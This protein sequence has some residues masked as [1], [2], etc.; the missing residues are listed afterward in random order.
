MFKEIKLSIENTS[1]PYKYDIKK[2][3]IIIKTIYDLEIG[4][5]LKIYYDEN[6]YEIV[7]NKDISFQNGKKGEIFI[8]INKKDLEFNLILKNNFLVKTVFKYINK[9][10]DKDNLIE[11]IKTFLIFHIEQ[12]DLNDL[13][14]NIL[15]N[16]K[17]LEELI[18]ENEDEY[19]RICTLL[20]NNK[21][22][23]DIAKNMSDLELM[24]LI[25]SYIAVPFIPKI[26]QETFNNLIKVA[27]D[28][29]YALENIWRLGMSF[30]GK[31]Y[32]YDLLDDFFVNQKDIWYLGE[33]LSGIYQVNQ[34][35]LVNKIIKT[36]DKEFI[37]QVLNDELI[38]RHLDDKYQKILENNI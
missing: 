3:E 1:I 21:T 18:I 2:D 11:E 38:S 24:L 35:K 37:K 31:G 20:I 27:Q 12:K 6:I 36:N 10:I 14:N 15:N 17:S 26:D 7:F 4:S 32:N 19:E 16:D 30:D 8:N 9:F 28:Y 22:Y 23:L 29:D 5:T 34:E 13:I 33:Y 25:T